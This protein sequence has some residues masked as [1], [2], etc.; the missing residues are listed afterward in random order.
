[1]TGPRLKRAI[2]QEAGFTQLTARDRLIVLP[3]IGRCGPVSSSQVRRYANFPSLDTCARR[4]RALRDLK[5]AIVHTPFGPNGENLYTLTPAGLHEIERLVEAVDDLDGLR[6]QRT[7]GRDLEHHR[8]VVDAYVHFAVATTR[9]TELTL[10]S[11]EL[12]WELRGR[13]HGQASAV[14]PDLV[15][16]LQGPRGRIAV[17][18]ECDL[19]T[20]N[21]NRMAEKARTYRARRLAGVVLAGEANWLVLVLVPTKRRRD[22]VALRL[23]DEDLPEGFW[24]Y[25]F[26]D[27]VNDGN[28]LSAVWDTVVATGEETANF[29]RVNPFASVLPS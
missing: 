12:D 28:I 11:V 4:L 7:L 18:V 9:S 29:A 21:P 8:A 6:V 24:F 23:M 25:G 26:G 17:A 13:A 5:L 14:V 22:R 16:V 1:M 19:G 2:P 10:V 27:E 3:F 20:M 15:V